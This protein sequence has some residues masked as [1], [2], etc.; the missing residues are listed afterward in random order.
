MRG[1]GK[2]AIWVYSGIALVFLMIP[3]VYT[4][5]FS[6]N[7][8]RRTNIIWRGFTFDNWL[9]VCDAQDVCQAFG[10][11]I[12]IAV[13]ATFI[14]TVLGTMIAIALVRYR[15][16]F[17]NTTTLLIFL[18]L[19]TPEVVL[20]A[21]LAAQFLQAGVPKGLGTV[22]IAHAL[23]CISFVIVTVRARVAGLDPALEEAGRD[24]YGSPQQ[25][26]WR[27]TF[28]LL[29]PGIIAAAL[30]SFALSFDDFIITNFNR[31]A[32]VTFPSFIYTAA[33]RGIPAEANVIASA[34]FLLAI[35]LVIIAQVGAAIR[36]RQRANA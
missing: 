2:Y 6:F 26:F 30:L 5:V 7:D 18:P 21:G 17:R 24:L 29:L 8:S 36:R 9:N 4:I 1:F 14:A 25:V 11:S 23:F 20:G 34:V 12:L 10:N 27:V 13:S 16:R 19:T 31:G 32:E 22:I 35:L 15:F 33:A 28:P 3:I